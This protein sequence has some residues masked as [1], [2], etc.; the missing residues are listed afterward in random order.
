MYEI[1]HDFGFAFAWLFGAAIVLGA[2]EIFWRPV[3]EGGRLC[4]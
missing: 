2:S 4:E 3:N 1:R